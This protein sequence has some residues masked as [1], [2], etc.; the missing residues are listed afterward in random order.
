MPLKKRKFQ[1][2]KKIEYKIYNKI[3]E[4]LNWIEDEKSKD[5]FSIDVYYHKFEGYV[6]L[7]MKNEF[8]NNI[9]S[10]LIL[11]KSGQMSFTTT[12]IFWAEIY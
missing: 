8:L 10:Y 6:E 7:C 2:K 3:E 5:I 12:K 4:N 9:Q 1:N 11:K